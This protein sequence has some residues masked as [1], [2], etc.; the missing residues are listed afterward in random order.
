MSGMAYREH[1]ALVMDVSRGIETHAPVVWGNTEGQDAPD[2][3]DALDTTVQELIAE[4]HDS[5][6][7]GT[8]PAQVIV[9]AYAM[10]IPEW[11]T[12]GYEK[13]FILDV[14]P[15]PRSRQ[16]NRDFTSPMYGYQ[17]EVWE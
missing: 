13:S 16:H 4:M 14:Y 1:P 15:D 8:S 9:R 2:F 5:R 17:F 3:Q 11:V 6:F 7:E 10:Q 12:K